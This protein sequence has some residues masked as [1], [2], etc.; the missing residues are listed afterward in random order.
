M[1]RD[2]ECPDELVKWMLESPSVSYEPVKE[3]SIAAVTDHRFDE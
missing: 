2:A 1:V 3:V